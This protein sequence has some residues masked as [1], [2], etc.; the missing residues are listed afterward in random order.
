MKPARAR[1]RT[2]NTKFLAALGVVGAA[3]LAGV[4]VARRVRSG[5]REAPTTPRPAS[6]LIGHEFSFMGHVL[7]ILESSRDTEDGSLRLDYSAPPQANISEHTHHFQEESFEVVSGNL[8]LRVGGQEL[9]L[10]H[11]ESAIGPPG[12]PH[13]WWN[14][15]DEERV[16]FVA[17]IRPGI[18]IETMFETLVSLMEQGKTFGPLP[19]NP[20]QAAVLTRE[21]ASWLVLGPLEK[22]LLAPLFALASVGKSLGYKTRYP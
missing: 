20:L 12:I 15:S 18:E 3:A 16:R 4:V 22:V 2:E 14:P 6:K 17:G 8:G 10:S 9:T 5:A 1:Y 11:G 7:R 13:A 21:I 19:R